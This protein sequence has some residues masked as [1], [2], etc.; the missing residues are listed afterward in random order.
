MYIHVYI[1]RCIHTNIHNRPGCESEELGRDG[2]VS[3]VNQCISETCY[4]SGAIFPAA[5]PIEEHGVCE[6]FPVRQIPT[7]WGRG[8]LG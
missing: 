8:R 7:H 3:G 2:V 5:C 4:E 1:H 6:H